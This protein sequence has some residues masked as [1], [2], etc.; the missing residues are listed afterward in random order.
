M[1]D[2]LIQAT[3]P[4]VAEKKGLLK[5]ID[6][7]LLTGGWFEKEQQSKV[8]SRMPGRS[9][10]NFQKTVSP[11]EFKL[12]V[13]TFKGFAVLK[14]EDIIVFEAEKNYT[15]IHLK[16]RKPIIVSRT[17][18]EYEKTLEGASFLRI[19]RSYLINIQHITEYHRGEGGMVIM[20]NGTEVE[21]SRR[22]KEFFFSKIKGMFRH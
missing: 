14:L 16:D 18:L 10:Y 12:C 7:D 13:P 17:L 5:P 1:N 11:A 8:D 9:L 20:S 15:I 19:H 6:Q 2:I 3:A 21:I 4:A 22:K